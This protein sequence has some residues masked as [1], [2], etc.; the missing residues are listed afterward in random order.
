[1]M[2]TLP[3]VSEAARKIAAGTLTSQRLVEMC[4]E[5]IAERESAVGA[6]EHLDATTALATARC[7]DSEGIRGVLHGIPFG[8]KDVIDAAGHP[9][10][11]GSPIYNSYVSPRDA[12]C[13]ALLK[14]A[15]AIFLGKTVSTELG[16]VTAGKTRN[17]R[18][19]QRTPGGSSS[20]SAAAVAAGMVPFALGTQT[21]GSVIR[22]AS[23]CGVVGYKPSYGDVTNSGVLENA[24]SFD[25]VGALCTALEDLPLIRSALLRTPGRPVQAAPLD[26]LRIGILSM[27][28]WQAEAAPMEELLAS[29]AGTLG[30]KGVKII[31]TTLPS[32]FEAIEPTHRCVSGYEFARA[33]TWERMEHQDKLSQ[34]LINGRMADGLTIKVENYHKASDV[35]AGLR[36]QFD[37]IMT[38]YDALLTPAAPGEA[39][40]GIEKTG[41]PIFNTIFSALHVPALTLPLFTGPNGCPIGLQVVGRS[42]QDERL[43]DVAAAIRGAI[44]AGS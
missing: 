17:P 42:R 3:G 15:G 4:L 35:L 21:T 19:L 2:V 23:F 20:G 41:D 32:D 33:L 24:S 1:M 34:S 29:V 18:N 9:T 27:P 13:V 43:F 7:K 38:D 26:A 14:E 39:P 36:A 40:I 44:G 37:T 10:T 31:R 5:A 6:W 28:Y 25:T 12:G 30:R 16:H 8:I 11:Y 22:P